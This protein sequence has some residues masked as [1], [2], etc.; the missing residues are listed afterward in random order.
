M[1]VEERGAADIRRGGCV[2]LLLFCSC[3][4]SCNLQPP[5]SIVIALFILIVPLI[6]IKG[7]LMRVSR[8]IDTHNTNTLL[9]RRLILC[10][11][12][13]HTKSTAKERKDHFSGTTYLSRIPVATTSIPDH[14]FFSLSFCVPPSPLSARFRMFYALVNVSPTNLIQPP[15]TLHWVE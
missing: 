14:V 13:S 12:G 11:I 6:Q 3:I 2:S 4:S 8:L 9:T 5:F 10:S 7:K 15:S 1:G